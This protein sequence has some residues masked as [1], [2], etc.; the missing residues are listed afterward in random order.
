MAPQQIFTREQRLLHHLVLHADDSPTAI[1][2]LNGK[3]GI[4]LVLA[5]YARVRQLRPIEKVAEYLIDELFKRLTTLTALDFSSGLSG[6]GWGVEYLLQNGYMQGVGAD[7]LSE[8]DRKLMEQYILRQDNWTLNDGL[9]GQLHYVITHIQGANQNGVKVFDE[10]FLES[11]QL[12]IKRS[13]FKNILLR[14]SNTTLEESFKRVLI[15]QTDVYKMELTPFVETKSR[16]N[17]NDLTLQ[18]GM[19]GALELMLVV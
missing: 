4:A 5:H 3:M 17:H 18:K 19:A 14:H 12:C 8:I 6:I 16:V 9:L 10:P 13:Q 2:L 7:L 11:W 1:G 15:G